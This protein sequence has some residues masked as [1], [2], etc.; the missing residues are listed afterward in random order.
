MLT[1]T[2]PISQTLRR[3]S[4]F[5]LA[6]LA[7]T[8]MLALSACGGGDVDEKGDG[9]VVAMKDSAYTVGGTVTFSGPAPGTVTLRIKEMEDGATKQ[10]VVANN[11]PAASSYTFR[12]AFEKE[13]R[14]AVTIVDAGNYQCI[15]TG[16]PTG[17]VGRANVTNVNLFCSVPP[18]ANS[19]A[20]FTVNG[21]PVGSTLTAIY[22]DGFNPAISKTF[23]IQANGA[24][25]SFDEKYV[26]GMQFQFGVM[27]SPPGYNC[28]SNSMV[29]WVNVIEPVVTCSPIPAAN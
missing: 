18:P 14:Y 23:T 3:R 17:Q 24:T 4:G 29:L 5:A 22:G 20:D 2:N 1:T 7:A 21:A 16:S 19:T 6:S 12:M 26:D 9:T 8:A 28:T 10:V 13:D 27:Q 15:F 25:Y 11:A